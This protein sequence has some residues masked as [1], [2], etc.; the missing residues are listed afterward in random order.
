MG[1]LRKVVLVIVVWLSS[2]AAS[3]NLTYYFEENYTLYVVDE[4]DDIHLELTANEFLGSGVLLS[5]SL[6]EANECGH[7][8]MIATNL[9]SFRL[10]VFNDGSYVICPQSDICVGV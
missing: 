2:G 8:A 9:G 5:G 6:M 4:N 7:S 3:A 10:I 1:L